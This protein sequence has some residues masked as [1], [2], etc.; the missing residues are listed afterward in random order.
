M[1]QNHKIYEEQLNKL[2]RATSED[3]FNGA[4]WDSRLLYKYEGSNSMLNSLSSI[5]TN[6][7]DR[8][9]DL[10]VSFKVSTNCRLQLI[11]IVHCKI[12]LYNFFIPS[13]FKSSIILSFQ[14]L[15]SQFGLVKQLFHSSVP[16]TLHRNMK[17]EMGT[18][19]NCRSILN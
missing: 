16:G 17:I 7:S 2:N 6:A 19:N 13:I 10:R 12:S 1:N 5:N 15:G 11:F 4:P 9:L 14:N 3:N 8:T 18:D